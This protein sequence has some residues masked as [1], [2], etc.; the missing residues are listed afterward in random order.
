[1]IRRFLR[2]GQGFRYFDVLRREGGVSEHGRPS[3][4]GFVPYGKFAGIIMRASHGE[5]EQWKSRDQFKQEGHPITHKII[6][7]GSELPVKASDILE[8]TENGKTR[9]FIV[10]GV[11]E[12]A[13]LGHFTAYFVEEREDLQ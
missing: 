3:V 7:S 4:S 9:R 1:M 5:V 10:K 13:E 8:S 2:P 11:T 12:P 6:Q